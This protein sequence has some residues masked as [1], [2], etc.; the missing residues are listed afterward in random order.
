MGIT[1]S[2]AFLTLKQKISEYPVLRLPDFEKEFILSTDASQT[3]IGAVLKQEHDG[4]KMPVM[5]ISRKLKPAETR[6]STIEREC[7]ALVWAT[8]R[9]HP[10]LYGRE[11][12][13]ETD[14]QPLFFIDRSKIDNDRIMRWALTLQEY[15][16]SIRVVKGKDNTTA[17]FLSRC[18]AV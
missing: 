3:G 7:L 5:Y 13:L 14:H 12:I 17:D 15:R 16:Y 8:K 10:Y 1:R 6:Y 11:F 4:M 9:L 2:K 18:G